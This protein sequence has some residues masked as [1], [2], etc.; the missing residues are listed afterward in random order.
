MRV[1][2]FQTV[3]FSS[4]SFGFQFIGRQPFAAAPAY[5]L[6]KDHQRGC[7]TRIVIIDIGW[8]THSQLES[9]TSFLHCIFHILSNKSQLPD[10]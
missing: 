8:F 7:R 6:P 10:G 2:G 5:L 3:G 9:G 4:R 1:N